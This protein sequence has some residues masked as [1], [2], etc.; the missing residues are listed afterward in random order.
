MI[1]FIPRVTLKNNKEL[2][3]KWINNKVKRCLQ[4]KYTHYLKYLF[5]LRHNYT[6]DGVICGKH[7][8]EYVKH[9]NIANSKKRKSRKQ[10]E[11]NIAEKCKTD[12]NFFLNM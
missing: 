2:K 10:Y 1:K 5:H 11:I 6:T 3:P 8:E 7:Y 12:H 9:R 4:K